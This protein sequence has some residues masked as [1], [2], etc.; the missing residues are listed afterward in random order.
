MKIFKKI[1]LVIFVVI[2]VLSITLNVV[3]GLSSTNKLL[4]NSTDRESLQTLYLNAKYNLENSN[5]RS[6]FYEFHGTEGE[7]KMF[8]TYNL[9]CER[10]KDDTTLSLDCTQIG[11]VYNADGDI[12]RI[13]YFPGDDHM[14]QKNGEIK[15]K[16]DYSNNSLSLFAAQMTT[17]AM[18]DLQ[19]YI[20]NIL[21]DKD[22]DLKSVMD[23]SVKFDFNTFSLTKTVETT[24][25]NLGKTIFCTLKFDGN[26]R[27]T[28]ISYSEKDKPLASYSLK[29]SY[30]RIKHNFPVLTDY[31]NEGV[32]E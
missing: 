18:V 28:S 3:L 20:P 24:T 19:M 23:V 25:Q 16:G 2:F 31:T 27:L 4:L 9:S 7:E 26:D 14:Y 12:S 6:F 29:I 10:P 8:Y 11:T 21:S 1:L 32:G 13:S 5:E 17:K 22:I 15:K 30:E